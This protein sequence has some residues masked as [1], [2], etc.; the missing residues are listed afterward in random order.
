M[1]SGAAIFETTGPWEDYATPSRDF[2]LLIAMRVLADLPARI[3]RHPELYVLGDRAAADAR[4]EVERLHAQRVGER[5]ITYVRSDGSPQT[6]TVAELLA[7]APAFETAYDP[8]DC[9]E[10]RWGAADGTPEQAT[11][12]RRAPADQRARMEQYRPWFREGRRPSR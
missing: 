4:A 12:R 5:R 3:T 11:C 6:L 1:P 7:R 9:V 8:N 2:R 10:V